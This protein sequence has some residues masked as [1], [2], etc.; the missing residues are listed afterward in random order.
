MPTQPCVIPAR[1][2]LLLTRSLMPRSSYSTLTSAGVALTG[3]AVRKTQPDARRVRGVVSGVHAAAALRVTLRTW[4]H[5]GER[6]CQVSEVV[7]ALKLHRPHRLRLLLLLM[8]RCC[9]C[10][11]HPACCCGQK[12]LE[13][14]AW[15]GVLLVGRRS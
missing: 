2:A 12:R 6:L 5:V 15:A 9:G 14:S 1:P 13:A 3:P 7:D 8:R 10:C 11:G 4:P